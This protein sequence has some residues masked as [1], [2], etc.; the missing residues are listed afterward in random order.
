MVAIRGRRCPEGLELE[1]FL[2]WRGG[3]LSRFHS[4]LD[5]FRC[6]QGF[7]NGES[8]SISRTASAHGRAVAA[9]RD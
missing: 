5:L 2:Q 6:F 1:H 4:S 3:Y 8:R 9:S 7:T